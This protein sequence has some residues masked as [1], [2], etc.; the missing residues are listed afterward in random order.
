MNNNG[1]RV[2]VT[3]QASYVVITKLERISK[4]TVTTCYPNQRMQE[5]GKGCHKDKHT[6]LH[7]PLPL[8]CT[9]EVKTEPMLTRTR[10]TFNTHF[11]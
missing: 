4:Q 9:A 7:G 3:Y 10:Y 6:D 5:F 1:R 11:Y 2:E 8:A